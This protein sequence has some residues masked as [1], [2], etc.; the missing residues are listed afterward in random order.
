MKTARVLVP[1]ITAAFFISAL[2]AGAIPMPA[3]NGLAARAPNVMAP[4]I[5]SRGPESAATDV[6][7]PA[8][9]SQPQSTMPEV[10]SPN[11]KK[12]K[13]SKSGGKQHP[14]RKGPPKSPEETIK[15][16]DKHIANLKKK[17]SGPSTNSK[18]HSRSKEEIEKEISHLEGVKK[19]YEAK[20]HGEGGHGH[21][22][23][24]SSAGPMD[25]QKPAPSGDSPDAP[26][27]SEPTPA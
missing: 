11:N 13:G 27:G 15:G 19:R 20:H 23:T 5:A 21:K 17:L 4:I 10:G 26:T 2:L 12:P 25:G 6:D 18:G 8:P 7:Q 22:G 1:S 16:I 14:H 3:S 24:S 9:D